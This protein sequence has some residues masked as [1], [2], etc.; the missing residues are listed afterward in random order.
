MRF[1]SSKYLDSYIESF[2]RVKN[3]SFRMGSEQLPSTESMREL[4]EELIAIFFPGY[5]EIRSSGMLRQTLSRHMEKAG[6][7]LYQ[8][9]VLAFHHASPECDAEKEATRVTEC[10]FSNLPQLREILKKDA[11]AGYDGDP[12]AKSVEEII[13]CYPAI[14]AIV[15][16]RVGHLLFKEGLPFIPRML[17]EIV[18]GQTGIDI[19]P[20]ATIGESFFIDHGTGVVIGETTIIGKNVKLY[21]GVTLGALSFPKDGCGMLLRDIRRHP[22]IGDNVT[23]YANASVLGPITIGK[24]SVIGSN[25]WIKENIPEN[26]RVL[27]TAPET[28]ISQRKH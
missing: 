4:V 26:S 8:A 14:R 20:G 28:T 13:L 5:E 27:T 15:I 2:S 3:D 7:L 24:N 25:A 9:A 17:N 21:Q 11:Q 1:D 23:I 10:L 22:T 18:H 16:H 12:A 19:H 6:D